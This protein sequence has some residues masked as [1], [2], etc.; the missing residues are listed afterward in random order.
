MGA[1]L[2]LAVGDAVGTT[3]EFQRPG[4]FEPIDDMVGGGPFR[5]PAGAWTDDTSM[6]LCLAESI[7][8]TGGMDLADQLRRYVAWRTHGHLSSTGRCFDIGITTS[9]QLARFE[10]TGEPVDPSPDQ[11]SAANGSLMRLAPVPIRWHADV[12][13]AAERSAES[14]RTTHAADRPVDACRVLGAMIAALVGGTPWEEVAD[15]SFWRWGPLHPAVEAVARGSWARKEP[16]AI[17]GSGYCIDALEAALWAV[18]GADDL[19]EAVLRAANLGDDADTTAAIAGQ[20]AGARWGSSGIPIRW[21]AQLHLRSR[22]AE[23]ARTLFA[24]G[25]GAVERAWGHDDALHAWWV[26][27]HVLAG[28]YPAA[29]DDP[30][31]SDEKLHVLLDA[32]VRT[33]VDLTDAATT[34]A[35]LTPYSPRLAAAADLRRL[36]LR[37]ISHPIPDRGVVDD[38]VYDDIVRTIHEH[39]SRG[40]VY[41]HCWGGVGRTGTVVG[42]LLADAGHA[43]HEIDA[44]LAELRSGTRKA[45]RGCPEDEHQRAVIRRRAA[46]RPS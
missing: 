44:R 36:D 23:L 14:S 24:A 38:H 21:R 3:L 6:A 17:R 8:D 27:D 20:L 1:L 32:G 46:A 33:F 4:T 22:I 42:C 26:D 39:R 28:E 37:R 15:P 10:R 2:G 12:A 11:E 34:D 41:V 25:G 13:E 35:H 5:L 16:P 40:A 7:A 19:R 45:H 31:R 29:K 18:A 9:A 43:D 30:V